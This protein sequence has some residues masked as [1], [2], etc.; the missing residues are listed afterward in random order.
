MGSSG[1]PPGLQA[2][3]EASVVVGEDEAQPSL[4]SGLSWCAKP[5]RL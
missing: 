4:L 3:V 1:R 5:M 2:E